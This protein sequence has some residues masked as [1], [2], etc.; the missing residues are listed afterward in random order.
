MILAGMGE[1]PDKRIGVFGGGF[2][3]PHSS[4]VRVARAAIEQLGLDVLF[5]VPCG[6]HPFKPG[7][8]SPSRMR[9]ALSSLT[10]AGIPRVVVDRLEI[11][12]AEME[13]RPSF[14]VETLRSLREREGVDGPIDLLIGSDNLPGLPRWQEAAALPDLARLAIYRREGHP[15]DVPAL[16]GRVPDHVVLDS[17][18]DTVSSTELRRRLAAGERF[19]AELDYES[20]EFAV[21]N[22]LYTGRGSSE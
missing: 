9:L 5:V 14:T 19:L 4:H 7:A 2:D 22:E 13:E 11:E 17:E 8:L 10:F 6:D 1:R 21:E 15:I 20:E 16:G 3:P 18:P 12:R